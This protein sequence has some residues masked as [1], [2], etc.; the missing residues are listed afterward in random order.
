M[1]IPRTINEGAAQIGA[2][3]SRA[4]RLSPRG[5]LAQ[6]P[7]IEVP[8]SRLP[9]VLVS[10]YCNCGFHFPPGCGALDLTQ[11]ASHMAVG[12]GKP[13][14]EKRVEKRKRK[15]S[16]RMMKQN[17]KYVLAVVGVLFVLLLALVYYWATRPLPIKDT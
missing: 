4:E 14:D 12:K 16:N 13:K 6:N 9:R 7:A 10:K 3:A 1:R 5:T 11:T 15:E 8:V 17:A 2:R